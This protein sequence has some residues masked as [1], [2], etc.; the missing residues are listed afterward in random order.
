MGKD[1]IMLSQ[2][3]V[4]KSGSSF[5]PLT[6]EWQ[7]L[8]ATNDSDTELF[9]N[10]IITAAGGCINPFF[11]RYLAEHSSR[12]FNRLVD[13]GVPLLRCAE[14]N[15]I[16]CFGQIPRGAFLTDLNAWIT[17]QKRLLGS[18]GVRR[19]EGLYIVSL[20]VTNGVCTGALALDK[21]GGLVCCLA[22]SVVLACGGGE[23]LFQ[24]AAAGGALLGAGYALA[25]R[26]GAR[27]VNLEFLQFL[28]GSIEP[29]KGMIYYPFA[30]EEQPRILSYRGDDCLGDYMPEGLSVERCIE[31]RSKHGPFAV[32]DDGKYLDLAM[33]EEHKKGNGLGLRLIPDEQ[34]L[35]KK[36][37]ELFGKFLGCMGLTLSSE[38]TVYPLC[39]G[40]NGGVL[41]AEDFSTDIAGLYACGESAGGIHG[42][43]RMGGASILSTQV[44]GEAAALAACAHADAI[45]APGELTQ[46]EAE[47]RLLADY[48]SG[49]SRYIR[50]QEAV[51]AIQQE[52]QF[53]GFVR[54]NGGDLK[55]SL[56][57]IEQVTPSPLDHL[58]DENLSDYFVAR[59]AAD[60]AQLLLS[61]MLAREESRG[62]HFREDYPERDG[63]SGGMNWVSL[64]DGQITTGKLESGHGWTMRDA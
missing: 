47:S 53:S 4:G 5:Y 35:S 32:E 46:R 62:G 37:Y 60:A 58:E 6:T 18:T 2:T 42:P 39:Q 48:G 54:R 12:A 8:Y 41:L 63:E 22:K 57:A 13:E 33:L 55:A 49:G 61:A 29:V 43:R 59:N 30:L 50:P 38:Q 28:I 3:P 23:G 19:F 26:R 1:V 14:V 16:G 64:K 25:A 34:R 21:Q 7:I 51:K 10:E 17:S 40:F 20:L 52:V 15:T 44:I 36:Q 56:R 9:Y 27:L 11:A 31:L 24:H 45:G